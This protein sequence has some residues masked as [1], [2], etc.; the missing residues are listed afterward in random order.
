MPAIGL[1]T[2]GALGAVPVANIQIALAA[3]ASE[4]PDAAFGVMVAGLIIVGLTALWSVGVLAA[5][6][7]IAL[8]PLAICRSP[9]I[10]KRPVARQA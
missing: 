4:N 8:R 3:Y 9:V 5:G 7:W 6:I 1:L 10:K 2:V